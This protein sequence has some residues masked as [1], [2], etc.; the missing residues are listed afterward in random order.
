M[1]YE[2]PNEVAY[3]VGSKT[4]KR[5]LIFHMHF[6]KKF[7][8]KFCFFCCGFIHFSKIAPQSGKIDIF[9][10]TEQT[11]KIALM[12]YIKANDFVLPPGQKAFRVN[13]LCQIN[14][15]KFH[16]FN[17]LYHTHWLGRGNSVFYKQ[18]NESHWKLLVEGSP[19]NPQ[20]FISLPED[21]EFSSNYEF[22]GRCIYDTTSL[23]IPLRHG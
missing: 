12:M 1:E 22:L 13:I 10:Q 17:V 19:Q 9:Y 11:K 5:F 16:V 2:L 15:E 20:Q 3:Q 4:L 21:K 14:F 18:K 8:S 23:D 6:K 7:M